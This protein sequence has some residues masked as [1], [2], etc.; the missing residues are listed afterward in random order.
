[1]P[2]FAAILIFWADSP[3]AREKQ[4]APGWTA[5]ESSNYQAAIDR[6][7]A[8]GGRGSILLKSIN[9]DS[10]GYAVRQRIRA[11]SWR[12][13]RLRFSG[14]IKTDQ[15]QGGGALWL[16][17]DMANGD[18]VLDGMLERSGG[19]WTRVEIVAA[20]P[21]DATGIS[22]GAR[23]IG[24]GQMWA[25]DLAFEIAPPKAPTTTIERRKGKGTQK[26]DEFRGA[27]LQP[28]NL[29]FEQ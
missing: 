25:D 26:L 21:V 8:H 18:Y 3:I 11:D 17:I 23:M 28:L 19:D 5:A 24:K 16:R 14:Y 13:K 15:V 20:I 2:L 29:S 1:M 22:F 6:K 12:G 10:Q 27:P 4:I 7:I 9:P